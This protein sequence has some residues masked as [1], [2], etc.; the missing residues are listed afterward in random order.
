MSTPISELDRL[1]ARISALEGVL[2]EVEQFLSHYRLWSFPPWPGVK[3]LLIR[4]RETLAQP[5]ATGRIT[6]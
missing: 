1:H 3:K 4:V 2:G 6:P 5:I